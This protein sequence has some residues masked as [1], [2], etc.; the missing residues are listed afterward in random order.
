MDVM[1]YQPPND[2]SDPFNYKLDY[3]TQNFF[4]TIHKKIVTYPSVEDE[5]TTFVQLIPVKK[6]MRASLFFTE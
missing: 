3:N 2:P 5:G 4:F 6:L 1:R